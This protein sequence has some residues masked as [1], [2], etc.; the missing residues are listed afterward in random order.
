MDLR[1][2]RLFLAVVDHGTFTAAAEAEL[3]AQPA[4]S[5]AVRELEAEVGAPLLVRS[6]HGA[7]LTPA[8]EA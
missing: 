5:L 3:V 7:V 4:V 1:R 8:G 6:R 2:L